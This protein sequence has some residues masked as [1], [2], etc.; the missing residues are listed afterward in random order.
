[1]KK[2]FLLILTIVIFQ[3][4]IHLSSAKTRLENFAYK[5][6]L[7]EQHSLQYQL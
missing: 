4:F 3:T 7:I 2:K 5:V 1:M 6:N